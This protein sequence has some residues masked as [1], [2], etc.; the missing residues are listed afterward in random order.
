M[1]CYSRA[2]F[3]CVTEFF[4][5]DAS[6]VRKGASLQNLFEGIFH[7]IW[8]FGVWNGNVSVNAPI[9]VGAEGTGGCLSKAL[10]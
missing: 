7:L 3:S 5:L 1:L 2:V 8:C 9:A 6:S 4:H 10:C